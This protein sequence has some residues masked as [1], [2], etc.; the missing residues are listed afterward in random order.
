MESQPTVRPMPKLSRLKRAASADG[1]KSSLEPI[2]GVPCLIE[3]ASEAPEID[4]AVV[5]APDKARVIG[6]ATGC[7]RGLP[8]LKEVVRLCDGGSMKRSGRD[9]EGGERG[10]DVRIG[11]LLGELASE[12]LC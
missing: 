5:P 11:K 6:N 12:S 2:E 7:C 3:D 8:L 9:V 1:A 4:A 10:K